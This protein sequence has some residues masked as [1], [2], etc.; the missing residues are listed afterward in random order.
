MNGIILEHTSMNDHHNH[1][2]NDKLH[3]DN[4]SSIAASRL[5]NDN[6]GSVFAEEKPVAV[7]DTTT[8]SSSQTPQAALA[9]YDDLNSNYTP[10]LVTFGAVAVIIASL[11][12]LE[13][14]TRTIM[15][16]RRIKKEKEAVSDHLTKFDVQDIDLNTAE[17][18]GW[19]GTFQNLLAQGKVRDNKDDVETVTDIESSSTVMNSLF[20]DTR[21][22]A[23]PNTTTIATNNNASLSTLLCDYTINNGDSDDEDDNN[24][25][26]PSIK[27]IARR[28]GRSTDDNI[29]TKAPTTSSG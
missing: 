13:I 21:I 20:M 11:L 14:A 6:N 29:S 27:M 28:A 19:H 16:K 22:V 3:H 23:R 9:F 17:T 8:S 10:L 25:I 7:E 24:S 5:A 12:L 1:E 4:F 15:Q 26:F 2:D 18:G